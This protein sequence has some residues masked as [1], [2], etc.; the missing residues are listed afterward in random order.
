M[1]AATNL[2]LPL[3]TWTVLGPIP[4]IG[5]GQFQF[6]DPAPTNRPHRLYR[7]RCP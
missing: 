2:S 1:L 6:I 7:V 3:S 5:P 4:E